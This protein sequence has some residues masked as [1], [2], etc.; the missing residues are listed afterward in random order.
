MIDISITAA[1]VQKIYSDDIEPEFVPEII[2][3]KKE[4]C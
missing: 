2:H 1:K 4:I 3:L